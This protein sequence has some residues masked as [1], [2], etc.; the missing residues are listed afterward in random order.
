[1]DQDFVMKGGARGRWFRATY[2]LARLE[3]SP[4]RL[5][6]ESP[7]GIPASVDVARTEVVRLELDDAG[8]MGR[9]FVVTAEGRAATSF[10]AP[11]SAVLLAAL[12]DRGWPVERMS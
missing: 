3:V 5:R 11:R 8:M 2:P 7:L 10:F 1:M 6:I 9:L 12:A 4:Q